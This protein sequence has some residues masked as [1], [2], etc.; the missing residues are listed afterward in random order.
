MKRSIGVTVVAMLSLIGSIL[1]RRW[2]TVIKAPIASALDAD[3]LVQPQF[4]FKDSFSGKSCDEPPT[5][6][7]YSP[8]ISCHP[9]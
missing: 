3:Q 6:N 9:C 8:G 2:T 4:M 5:I 7:P 1:T